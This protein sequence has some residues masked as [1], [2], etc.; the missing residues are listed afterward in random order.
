[1][2]RQ[3]G[4]RGGDP[5]NRRSTVCVLRLSGAHSLGPFP[6]LDHRGLLFRI[7][8]PRGRP[9]QVQTLPA[10]QQTDLLRLLDPPRVHVPHQFR[11]RRA[12][13]PARA[14]RDGDLLR[15]HNLRVRVGLR[16]FTSF[17]SPRGELAQADV[18]LD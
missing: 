7:R 9:P 4:L 16:H 2:S 6:G 14:L 12:P 13:P 11:P 5:R 3:S 17:R 15:Q 18:L 1:V 8:R 10:A